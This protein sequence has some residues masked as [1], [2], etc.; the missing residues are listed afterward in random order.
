MNK[1]DKE[2]ATLSGQCNCKSVKFEATQG[3]GDVYICHCSICQRKSG[4]NGVAVII[5]PKQQFNFIQGLSNIEQWQKPGH[6]WINCF[7]K[8]C[9]SP[10]PGK[11]C[12]ET[13]FIPVGLLDKTSYPLS[14]KGHIWIFQ[15]LNGRL[16]LITCR[17]TLET[18][19]RMR[20]ITLLSLL[21][22]GIFSC[23]NIPL[24][25]LLTLSRYDHIDLF[26][27]APE[28]LE[29]GVVLSG[30]DIGINSA[31]LE[32]QFQENNQTYSYGLNQINKVQRDRT[33]Y[34]PAKTHYNFTLDDASITAYRELMSFLAQNPTGNANNLRPSFSAAIFFKH[35]VQPNE[36][37]L[38]T[39]TLSH[40]QFRRSLVLFNEIPIKIDVNSH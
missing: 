21:L 16:L 32:M 1:E 31:R 20:K 36:V 6:D 3:N 27:L 9:G 22:F 8:R 7:C 12:E 39:V 15:K 5:V 26:N 17:N 19:A 28:S 10:V 35:P 34:A 4:G 30:R 37:I 2:N 38:M 18:L 40:P 29:V 14:V 11:N 25:T 33:W 23:A 24:T 13:M